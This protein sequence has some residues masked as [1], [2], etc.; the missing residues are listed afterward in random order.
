MSVTVLR[1]LSSPHNSPFRPI[2]R[3]LAGPE[4]TLCRFDRWHNSV[5]PFI[6]GS[7]R[8]P[9]LVCTSLFLVPIESLTGCLG[10]NN[11][12]CTGVRGIPLVRLR[13]FSLLLPLG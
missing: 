1:L 5:N 8:A 11:I 13:R 12:R 3:T 2:N 10:L 7:P 9:A 6:T 4:S